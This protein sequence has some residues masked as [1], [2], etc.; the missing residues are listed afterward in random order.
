MKLL[1]LVAEIRSA[2]RALKQAQTVP[3]T[4]QIVTM[5]IN[6]LPTVSIT[7]PKNANT[8]PPT[9]SLMILRVVL[10]IGVSTAKEERSLLGRWF[11]RARIPFSRAGGILWL[12]CREMDGTT[13]Y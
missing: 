7:L 1:Y 9:I 2:I 4:V 11:A 13:I 10:R 3:P 8:L 5:A 6:S 12:I